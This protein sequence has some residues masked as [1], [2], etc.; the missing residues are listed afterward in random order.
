[1]I[2]WDWGDFGIWGWRR[3]GDRDKS[4]ISSHSLEIP[5]AFPRAES[6]DLPG[7]V[8]DQWLWLFCFPED[9][10]IPGSMGIPW[11]REENPAWSPF[12][13]PP[14]P[15]IHPDPKSENPPRPQ[16]PKSTWIPNPPRPQILKSIQIPKPS[17]TLNLC[18]L[19]QE[20]QGAAQNSH[21][22]A[23]FNP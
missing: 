5:G 4:G 22:L 3:F 1:M 21:F 17:Q 16:T 12:L 11:G 14:N 13:L 19:P 23:D 2:P 15:K 9:P 18:V 6:R 7:K 10:R 8:W 20:L